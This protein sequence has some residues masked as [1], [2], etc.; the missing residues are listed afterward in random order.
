MHRIKIETVN[1]KVV[2]P[3]PIDV[4]TRPVKGGDI[5][6]NPYLNIFSVAP[7]ASGKTTALFKILKE[8]AGK[9]TKIVAFVS[10]IFND[11]NWVYIRRWAKKMNIQLEAHDSLYNEDGVNILEGYSKFFKNEAEE[12]EMLEEQG[13]EEVD[14]MMFDDPAIENPK[15]KESKCRYPEWIFIFDDLAGELRDPSF[16]KFLK[17]SR[18]YRCMTISSSQDLKDTTPATRMQMRLW[19]L[20]GGL[21]EERLKNVYEGMSLK[22]P[23]DVFQYLY[24][25]ATKEKFGFLYV[26]PRT[27]DFR[28]NFN[29]KFI[30]NS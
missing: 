1:D 22:I 8:V 17:K 26:S 18:Q 30:I 19:L 6:Y 27:E 9:K 15:P 4:D 3:I 11:D 20:F 28:K 12:R 25:Y 16:E 2:R 13:E 10:T 24:K 29:E 5:C 7:T 14:T 23:F 21:T